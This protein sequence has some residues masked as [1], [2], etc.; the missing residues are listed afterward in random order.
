MFVTSLWRS[1]SETTIG[2]YFPQVKNIKSRVTSDSG[3][4]L[5]RIY[6]K[7][8]KQIIIIIIILL[9]N[10]TDNLAHIW[11]FLFV[12]FQSIMY[13]IFSIDHLEC[14]LNN[15]LLHFFRSH[16]GESCVK[17][18]LGNSC[19]LLPSCGHSWE[20]QLYFDPY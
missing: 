14:Q 16:V 11:I 7:K 2:H 1:Y 9:W 13:F 18:W 19:L 20:L 15:Y 12:S 6:F 4:N 5:W 10:L 3:V 17:S 8:I